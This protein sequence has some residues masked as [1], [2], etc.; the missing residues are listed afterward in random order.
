M[1]RTTVLTPKGERTREHLLD[2]AL[3]LFTTAGYEATTMRDIA[4]AAE[5]SLGLAYRYFTGKE[6]FVLALYGRME[7]EFAAYVETLPPAPLAQRFGQTMRAKL[8]HIA[9][10]R[11]ALGALAG[12]ALNPRSN[13]AV[14]GD[15]TAEVRQRVSGMFLVVV[16]GATDAPREQVAR[17]LATVLY[18][19]HLALTLFWLYDRSQNQ[20]AT[21]EL[22]AL[23]CDMLGIVRRLLRLP[24]LAKVLRRLA[25][26]MG[27]MFDGGPEPMPAP[28]E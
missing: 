14:L 18:G 8:A 27:P 23:V 13:V 2:T 7:Q 21:A 4:T 3:R 26:I 19:A 20:R 15:T 17:D 12:A 10:Y 5:C 9:P 11:E 28:R 24:P 25:R 1:Q 6:E 22:L 16:R